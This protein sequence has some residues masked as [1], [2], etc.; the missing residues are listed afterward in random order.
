MPESVDLYN[1]SYTNYGSA[2]YRDVRLET[3]GQDFGQTSWVNGEESRDIP[4]VL[5]LKRDSRVLEI[6]CGSGAYALHL[7]KT[8][9]CTILGVD[10]NT[11]GV[12]NA[13]QLARDADLAARASFKH[14]DAS[15]PL[16]FED[17]SFDA[18][19]S[20]D[21]LCHI[22]GRLQL[23]R[24]IFRV[25]KPGGRMLFSD[26]LV[27][28]GM[29]SYEEIATRS[30]IGYYIYTPPGENERLIGLADFQDTHVTDTTQN[31][32]CIAERWYK[33]REKREKELLALEGTKNFEGLQAFL[34]CVHILTAER[35][36]L[37]YLYL[38]E[39]R[40]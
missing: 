35:R 12:H 34:S 26:A 2:V 29:I 21:A 13:N 9:E 8:I 36:L 37:R 18:V 6:G 40:L 3:Y 11:T 1:T 32:A 20:N 23:L 30:S 4:Q 24:E 5:L 10:L 17:R 28:G 15:N 7:A 22:P 33:A 31:A 16:P 38:A 25:L 19:F 14:C 27:L 39:K